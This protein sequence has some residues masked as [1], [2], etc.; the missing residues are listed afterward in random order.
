MRYLYK[1]GLQGINQ[2]YLI[3]HCLEPVREDAPKLILF[4]HTN[5]QI[6]EEVLEYAD[7]LYC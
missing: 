5:E 4:I 6:P 1:V 7:R 3:R 2:N